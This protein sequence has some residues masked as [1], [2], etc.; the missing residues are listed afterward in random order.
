[1][2]IYC[3]HGTFAGTDALGM[4]T[5]LA[6]F[7][8]GLSRSLSNFGKQTFNLIAGESGN[9]TQRFARELQEH[10]SQGAGRHIPVELFHWSSQNNHIARAD[11]AVRLIC[12]L[13]DLAE[14]SVK[15]PSDDAPLPRVQL[16]GHSHGGNVFSLMTN[17]LGKDE[18]RREAFFEAAGA[19]YRTWLGSRID[20]P[21]WEK[22]REILRDADHPLRQLQLDIVTFGTPVRYG[23]D[24][25]GYANLLN[26][27]NHQPPPKGEEHQAPVP[28]RVIPMFRGKDGDYV[29]QIGIAG[30]NFMPL[31]LFPRTLQADLRLDKF[32]EENLKSENLLRRLKNGTRVP[33]EGTTL[34]VHYKDSAFQPRLMGH[35]AYTRRGWLPFHCREIAARFY[36]AET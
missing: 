10:V 5:E 25:D 19:F 6:R 31:P 3:V 7:A 34:L 36:G 1:M 20:M 30:S 32:L 23:W 15:E 8:P 13:A 17:L 26:F 11:G 35:A 22:A 21:D 28:M 29:Q 33:E 4:F 2:A 24:T 12:D 16:W 27:I 14:L 18:E 9:Y